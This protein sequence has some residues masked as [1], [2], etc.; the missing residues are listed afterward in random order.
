[1]AEKTVDL[2]MTP[3][4]SGKMSELN[5]NQEYVA[6]KSP[7][8][9]N[10]SAIQMD[11]EPLLEQPTSA[12][13]MYGHD[14]VMIFKYEQNGELKKPEKFTEDAYV[15]LF[16]GKDHLQSRQNGSIVVDAFQRIFSL[17]SVLFR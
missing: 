14:L 12:K 9:V 10:H 6:I 7:R 15:T 11:F 16:M 17:S 3:T 4:A 8:S 13:V 2:S 1:M 5:S